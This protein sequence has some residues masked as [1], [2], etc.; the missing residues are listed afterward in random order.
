MANEGKAM[1]R[2]WRTPEEL[3]T[4]A[5]VLK[6]AADM[7]SNSAKATRKAGMESVHVHSVVDR[8]LE[9]VTKFARSV[10]N[11]TDLAV[12]DHQRSK[13]DDANSVRRRTKK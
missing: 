2:V 9:K 11:D 4:M 1:A 3:E 6:E 5:G 13:K 12:I 8:L 7:V 10:K